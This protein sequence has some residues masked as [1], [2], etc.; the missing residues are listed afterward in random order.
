[1]VAQITIIPIMLDARPAAIKA[2]RY[3][4]RKVA[5]AVKPR[6]GKTSAAWCAQQATIATVDVVPPAPILAAGA[7]LTAPGPGALDEAGR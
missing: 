4:A 1:M 6:M 2:V 7:G 5:A 3:S